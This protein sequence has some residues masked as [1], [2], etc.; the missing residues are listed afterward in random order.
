MNKKINKF[1]NNNDELING[2]FLNQKE[3]GVLWY[4]KWSLESRPQLHF[5]E[6]WD[7]L[8]KLD[9]PVFRKS[10]ISVKKLKIKIKVLKKNK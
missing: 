9:H 5:K 1:K 10:E 3:D 8:F 2:S 6:P 7:I 4:A